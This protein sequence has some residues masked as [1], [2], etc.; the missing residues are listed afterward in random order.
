MADTQTQQNQ[1]PESQTETPKDQPKANGPRVLLVDDDKYI[2][3]V[4]QELLQSEG[5][6][7]DIASDG[8]EALDLVSA[9][10]YELVI[11]DVIMPK[12]DGIGI[13][14][15][16]KDHPAKK[17]NKHIL[18]LTNL[19]NDPAVQQA[20]ELGADECLVKAEI[21]PGKFLEI[22]GKYA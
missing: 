5:Y 14:T 18:V 3:D 13:L 9:G 12:I 21:N 8:Q 15:E 6:Q 19:A 7:V 16:L 10:G 2:R 20:K 4:Y 22:I 1:T 17:K 11:L